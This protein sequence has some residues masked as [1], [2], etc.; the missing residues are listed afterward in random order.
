MMQANDL[1]VAAAGRMTMEDVEG[2]LMPW[3]AAH[4][5]EIRAEA[6]DEGMKAATDFVCD[7]AWVADPVNPYQKEQNDEH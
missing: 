6:W 3:L 4:D 2:W 1:W 7:P 5:A